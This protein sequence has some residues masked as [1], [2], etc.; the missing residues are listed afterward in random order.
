MRLDWFLPFHRRTTATY[1]PP[2]YNLPMRL[3]RDILPASLRSQENTVKP[4]PVRRLLRRIGPSLAASPFRRLSQTLCF[5]LFAILFF[6]VAFPY[7]AKP[8]KVW[9]GWVAAN[10]NAE[11][12]VVEVEAPAGATDRPPAGATVYAAEPPPPTPR[13]RP[14]VHSI[15]AN[16][17]SRLRRRQICSP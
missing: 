7:T 8:A 16:S 2:V 10:V 6:Y 3:L 13:R 11:T 17:P 9:P 5:V 4:G 15:S 1:S 12:G 14:P